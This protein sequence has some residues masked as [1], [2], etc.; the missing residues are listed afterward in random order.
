[1]LLSQDTFLFQ[2][3]PNFRPNFRRPSFT[4]KKINATVSNDVLPTTESIVPT[5]QT[6]RRR[7]PTT[8]TPSTSILTTTEPIT[9]NSIKRKYSS[10]P[11]IDRR[12]YTPLSTSKTTT[13][14]TEVPTTRTEASRTTNKLFRRRF[15]YFSTTTKQ[16]PKNASTTESSVQDEKNRYN[17]VDQKIEP[18]ILDTKFVNNRFNQ[19][20]EIGDTLKDD[21][22]IEAITTISKAPLPVSISSTSKYSNTYSFFK[23][24][25]ITDAYNTDEPITKRI[26]VNYSTSKSWP[27]FV[28]L[29]T[30]WF[31]FKFIYRTNNTQT[32][33]SYNNNNNDTPAKTRIFTKTTTSA[34]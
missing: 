18:S 32:S 5:Y 14:T 6:N 1:M 31:F 13:S 28:G 8:T 25:D 24:E 10:R 11:N 4:T 34:I 17:N 15:N 29:F 3:R 16:P 7:R 27:N 20:G 9:K 26:G 30:Y 21:G 2:I 33:N 19:I 22:L 23:P 12:R